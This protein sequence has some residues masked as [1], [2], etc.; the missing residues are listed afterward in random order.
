VNLNVDMS[1]DSEEETKERQPNDES[2][3]AKMHALSLEDQVSDKKKAKKKTKAE[4]AEKVEKNE[5][6]I[7][8]RT[9]GKIREFVKANPQIKKPKIGVVYD[10]IMTLHENHREF[11]SERP[12]RIMAIYLNLI[13]KGIYEQLE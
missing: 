12:E 7:A 6:S 10:N 9:R 5:S 1:R 13:D 11:H 2:L 3:A 8:G 4:K